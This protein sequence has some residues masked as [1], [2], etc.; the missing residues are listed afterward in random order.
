MEKIISYGHKI[1]GSSSENKSLSF[2][3]KQDDNSPAIQ[4]DRA[5]TL[6]LSDTEASQIMGTLGAKNLNFSD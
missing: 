2:D 3:A 6:Q 1:V 4:N 5:H